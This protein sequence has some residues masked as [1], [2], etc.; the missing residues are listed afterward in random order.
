[1]NKMRSAS[2]FVSRHKTAL[3]VLGTAAAATYLH[4]KVI[5]DVNER[6]EEIGIDPMKFH[7]PKDEF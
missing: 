2:K 3:A 7:S 6:L 1:M 4:L 5:D